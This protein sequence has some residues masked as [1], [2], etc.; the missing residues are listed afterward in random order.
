MSESI[1]SKIS[2]TKEILISY[3]QIIDILPWNS[4]C[5]ANSELAQ[6]KS[7]RRVA[8]VVSRIGLSVFEVIW[9]DT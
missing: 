5:N 4:S 9:R 1:I 8:K 7:K 3:Y 2:N 6:S